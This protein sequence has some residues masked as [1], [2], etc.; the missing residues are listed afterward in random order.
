MGSC[1]MVICPPDHSHGEWC[2]YRHGCQCE[3]CPKNI[4]RASCERSRKRR[5]RA[6]KNATI[7]ARGVMRRLQALAA[8]G[9]ST[10]LISKSTG[11]SEMNLT[12]M[13][14]GK[15]PLIFASTHVKVDKFYQEHKWKPLKGMYADRT[16]ANARDRDWA[17]PVAWGNIDRDE[18]PYVDLES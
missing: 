3:E 13:R 1:L 17:P 4:S 14:I 12:Y 6:G 8:I 18:A 2:K 16:R 9:Y 10:G 5:L 7:S 15:K 11:I